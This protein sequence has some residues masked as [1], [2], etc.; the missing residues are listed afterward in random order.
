MKISL[1]LKAKSFFIDMG[2][3]NRLLLV[4]AIIG[5]ALTMLLHYLG[6]YCCR[7]AKRFACVGFIILC[8]MMGNSFAYP[9]FAGNGGFISAEEEDVAAAPADSDISFVEQQLTAYEDVE[10]LEEADI[11][12]EL[13]ESELYGLEDVDTYLLDEILEESGKSSPEAPD[14]EQEM[15][16]EEQQ[17]EASFRADD[18]RLVLIN[19][20]HPIPAD[21][22]FTLGAIKT[23]KGTMQCDERVI[24]E[25]LAMMQGASQDGVKLAICSPYRDL[26]YQ[27]YLFDR[28]I[29]AYMAKG[30]SYM[31]A[32][33][34]SSQAVTVP[35][36]SEHQIGLSF[37]IV[38]DT[39]QTL[40][41]GFAKTDA[42]MW[43]AENSWRYGFILRYPQ[44]KEHITSIEFEPWHF[45][46][47]GKEAAEIIMGEKLT[48][49]EFWEYYL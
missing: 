6:E 28:K 45:R 7:G 22:S 37:D 16:E 39:Y 5:L 29:K 41:E 46:Y 31:D 15:P 24:E 27:E 38:S 3:R 35:G 32:Y 8:F 1:Y 23:I 4:P 49:E 9:V 21:Y 19:K 42:G 47:V 13:D 33:R 17:A 36:A 26:N 44:G 40:D 2:R 43:L 10:M 18:W 12:E 11:L 30:M 34:V 14:S 48:L 20:Q 25:L